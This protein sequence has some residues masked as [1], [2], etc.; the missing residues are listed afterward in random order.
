VFL[1]LLIIF[2]LLFIYILLKELLWRCMVFF[3]SKINF[4]QVAGVSWY[5][6]GG[7]VLKDQCHIFYSMPS[8]VPSISYFYTEHSLQKSQ[9]VF[10]FITS[11]AVNVVFNFT[12]GWCTSVPTMSNHSAQL[13]TYW[14][15]MLMVEAVHSRF[16]TGNRLPRI[17]MG[18]LELI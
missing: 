3:L 16:E 1:C 10:L 12:F 6:V 11:S 9:F 13:F 7:H 2:A 18:L 15:L 17:M 8:W 14:F 4:E 5:L